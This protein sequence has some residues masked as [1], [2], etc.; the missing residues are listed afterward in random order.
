MVL[1]GIRWFQAFQVLLVSVA[2]PLDRNLIELFVQ[3]AA[4]D[5]LFVLNPLNKRQPR[6]VP[7]A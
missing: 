6:T 5:N 2:E 3:K 1:L 7:T 4:D